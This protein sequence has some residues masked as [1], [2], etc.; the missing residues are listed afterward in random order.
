MHLHDTPLA[1]AE[2]QELRAAHGDQLVHAPLADR[3]ARLLELLHA[4][5]VIG[6]PL[7]EGVGILE[8]DHTGALVGRRVRG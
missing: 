4:T 3:R 6:A 8:L 7:H 5:E 2:R 1:E